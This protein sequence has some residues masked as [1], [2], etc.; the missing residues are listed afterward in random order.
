[1]VK[2]TALKQL[3]KVKCTLTTGE[4]VELKYSPSAE[5]AKQETD[6]NNI[7]T[8][9]LDEIAKNFLP[10]P[11]TDE[12]F[13]QELV[14]RTFA[15]VQLFGD[16]DKEAIIQA[17][18]GDQICRMFE[19]MRD[20]CMEAGIRL[21]KERKNKRRQ[22]VNI[23]LTIVPIEKLDAQIEGLRYQYAILDRCFNICVNHLRPK[24]YGET[25]INFG[26]Y[27]SIKDMPKVRKLQEIRRRQTIDAL[28]NDREVFDTD[29][30]FQ[31]PEFVDEMLDVSNQ[32]GIVEMPEDLE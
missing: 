30:K 8:E 16:D 19:K 6:I 4:R 21:K 31:D 3:D 2:L 5:E 32:E 23:E 18:L 15:L 7:T 1:M 10:K 28:M 25:G 9:M 14:R 26:K 11:N 17:K 22:N 13:Q 12:A 24:V 20:S 29:P 27:T